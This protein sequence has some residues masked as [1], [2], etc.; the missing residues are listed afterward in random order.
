MQIKAFIVYSRAK[1]HFTVIASRT[2]TCVAEA[3]KSCAPGVRVV[4]A[5]PFEH[6]ENPT[7]ERYRALLDALMDA[8]DVFQTEFCHLADLFFTA[9][10]ESAHKDIEL[11]ETIP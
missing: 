4:A 7:T 6:S 9:G 8:S 5:I 10:R 2:K 11:L 3:Q 1:G